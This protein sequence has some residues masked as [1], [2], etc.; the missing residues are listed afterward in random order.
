MFYVLNQATKQIV[1][2]SIAT[3]SLS[4][5]GAYTLSAAPYSVAIAPNG[6]FLYVGTA[7]GIYLFN[8]SSTGSLTLANNSNVISLDTASTMQ[9]DST[10]NWLLEAGPNLPELIAIHISSSTGVPTSSVEQ[11]TGLP[12]S[13]VKQLVISPDNAHVFVALGSYGTEDVT[14]A[15]GNANPFG[16]VANIAVVNAGGGAVSVAVDPS[17]RLLYVGETAALSGTNSGGLRVFNYSTLVEISGSPFSTGGTAPYAIV[18]TSYGASAGKFVYVANRTVS[19][20]STGNIAGFQVSTTGTSSTLLSLGT[21][22]STGVNPVGL[23]Q[24]SAGSYILVV[25]FGGSP[26]LGAYTIG[27]G[28]LTSAFT[29]STGTDPVQATAIAAAP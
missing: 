17:S 4:Q 28:T 7:S 5:I 19:G 8:I 6:G 24:D 23:T 9:V 20:I 27:S 29:S 21:V 2:Y 13:T 16:T 11:N 26:D 1:A 14:F 22:A 15:A 18:P 3:G 25:N 10:N 12:S